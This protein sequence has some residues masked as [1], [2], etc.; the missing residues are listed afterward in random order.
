MKIVWLM[1]DP[2][3]GCV[4]TLAHATACHILLAFMDAWTLSWSYLWRWR[5][6]PFFRLRWPGKESTAIQTRLSFPC[7]VPSRWILENK[8]LR[9]KRK[10][11]VG[12]MSWLPRKHKM[13]TNSIYFMISP[14][15]YWIITTPFIFRKTKESYSSGNSIILPLIQRYTQL[16]HCT[17]ESNCLLYL[18][19]NTKKKKVNWF[20]LFIVSYLELSFGYKNKFD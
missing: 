7:I 18:K 12:Q 10:S 4:A 14:F 3:T 20:L 6:N 1:A 16:P 17:F 9:M 2:S 13:Y 15:G 11:L 8:C 5:A 19:S